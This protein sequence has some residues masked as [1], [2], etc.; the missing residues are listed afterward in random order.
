MNTRISCR[1]APATLPLLVA[2]LGCALSDVQTTGS[3]ATPTNTALPPPT[4]HEVA[5]T[6]TLP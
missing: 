4:I 3:A 6:A 1:G 2:S 5:Q